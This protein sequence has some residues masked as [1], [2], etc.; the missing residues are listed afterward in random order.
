MRRCS[1]RSWCSTSRSCCRSSTLRRLAPAAST[2]AA[3]FASRAD[4]F[5]ACRIAP[6]SGTSWPIRSSTA[7]RSSSSL[8]ASAFSGSAT[9]APA[10]WG[11][12]SASSRSTPPAAA[13]RRTPRCRSSSTS[14]P[15]I[16]NGS[17]IRSTSA[18]ITHALQGQAVRRFRRGGRR[19]HRRTL[20]ARPAAVG[21][22]RQA[23]RDAAAGALR[24]RLCTFNDD[25]QGTAAVATGALLAAI[26]VTGVPLTE[27]RIAISAPVRPA[28][29]SQV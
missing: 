27:Q 17:P 6:A 23:Q 9:R 14:A 22:F 8:T 10:A 18:G 21:G 24:D 26:G 13:S 5:S 16:R 20:A 25:I 19:R 12:R 29:A 7:P 11:F 28:A 3:C 15:T 4:C 2:S 1:T